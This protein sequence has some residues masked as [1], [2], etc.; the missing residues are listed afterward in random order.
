MPVLWLPVDELEALQAVLR[1]AEEV[2]WE[3]YERAKLYIL[4]PQPEAPTAEEHSPA[5]C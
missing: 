5:E 2:N 4:Q 1:S 3:A